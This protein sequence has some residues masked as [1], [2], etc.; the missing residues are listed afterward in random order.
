MTKVKV[1]IVQLCSKLD[2]TTN[3]RTIYRLLEDAKKQ[4]VEYIFL[5]E[6]FYSM[7]GVTT[8]TPYLVEGTNEHYQAIRK[9]AVDNG[10]YLIGGSAAT[11]LDNRIVNRAYN[12][13]PTGDNLGNYDKRHLFS[14]DFVK[15]GKR[16]KINEADVYSAGSEG[17]IIEVGPLRIG[18]SICFDLRFSPLYFDYAQQGVNIIT[19]ASAFTVPTGRAHWHTLVRARAIETQSFVIA[20]DQWGWHND[21]VQTFGHSLIVSPWGEILADA[22]EGEKF[23]SAELD[24]SLAEQMRQMIHVF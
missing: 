17:Q 24:L 16:K 1:G 12:F 14:C 9:I 19:I 20:A 18:L 13:S 21:K 23:I 7:S 11:K 4:A 5:P 3:L 2:P 8:P 10:V 6:V 22:Q 15:D